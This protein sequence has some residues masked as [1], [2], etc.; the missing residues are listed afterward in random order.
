M[1]VRIALV[2]KKAAGKSF[3]AFYLNRNYHFKRAKLHAGV[4][5]IV[6]LMYGDAKYQRPTWQQRYGL[7]DALYKVDPN[8]HISYLADRLAS[9]TMNVVVEDARYVNEVDWLSKNGFLIIRVTTDEDTRKRRIEGMKHATVGTMILNE[10]FNVDP[11]R[12]Y[13]VDYNILNSTRDA[14]RRSIDNLMERL[15]IHK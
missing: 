8:I 6:K 1:T 3:V 14:T 12:A 4:D 2:G 7:Y 10:Y 5:R 9:T 13:K 11:S 15:D